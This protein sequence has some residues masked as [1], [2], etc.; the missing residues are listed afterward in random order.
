MA[1][2]RLGLHIN[3]VEAR[4]KRALAAALV[5]DTGK[6][7]RDYDIRAYAVVGIGADGRAHCIWDTGAILP[8]WAFPATVHAALMRD[9]ECSTVEEDWKPALTVKGGE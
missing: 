8:M 3:K 4:R 9:L 5:R 1:T 2:I 6:M 7:V